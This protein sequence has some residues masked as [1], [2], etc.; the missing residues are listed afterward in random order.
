M[1]GSA[2]QEP[3]IERGLDESADQ[4]AIDFNDASWIIDHHRGNLIEKI[5]KPKEYCFG[6][7]RH[8][9]HQCSTRVA[10]TQNDSAANDRKSTDVCVNQGKTASIEK[11]ATNNEPRVGVE[12]GYRINLA[13]LQRLRLRQLQRKLVQH[14]VDLRYDAAEPVGWAD[15]L[16][17][18]VQ[19]LKDYDYMGQ[20]IWKSYDPFYITCE[21]FVER[22][23]MQSAMEGMENEADPLRWAKSVG[24]W[25]TERDRPEPIGGTRGGNFRKAWVKGF[26]Q[27]VSV[28]AVGGAFLIGPMWLMVLHKTLYTA[29]VSTTVFVVLFGLVMAVWLD[30]LMDVMSAT[31]AYAA[32]LVVFVGLTTG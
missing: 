1:F 26:Q 13:E 10:E 30:K 25:E 21:R 32:V 6:A 20:F 8:L 27:R 12:Q 4:E 23:M 7:L 19:T 2:K 11:Y 31:A 24:R 15:D 3:D 5:S 18:Y 29:L 9:G 28:A 22:H 16:R 14:V 17:D